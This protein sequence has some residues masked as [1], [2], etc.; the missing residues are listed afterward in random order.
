MGVAA[1]SCMK[2]QS[3]SALSAIPDQ[4]GRAPSVFAALRHRNY[5]LYFGG[6]LVSNAGTWMQAIA[7]G[8]LVYQL[9]HSDLMLGIVG[10]AAA[11]PSLLVTPWGGV[12]VDRMP[13]R[14]LLLMTQIGAM[15]LAF[16]LAALTFSGLVREWQIVL[17]AA[18]LGFVNAFDA[19]ARQA[20]VVEMVGRE[21]LPNAIALN[22]LMFNSARVI[23][24]A[25][26]GILLTIVGA[27]WCFTINGLSFLA[28]L[29]GLAA[30]RM[31]DRS[32]TGT[33][34]SP[35]N[36]L[37]QGLRYLRGEPV[38]TGILF[39]SLF[40]SVFGFSYSTLLPAF[41]ERVLHQGAAVYGWVTSATGVGAVT[42]ALLIASQRSRRP[43]GRWLAVSG[44]TFPF[45]LALF[46]FTSQVPLS[47]MLAFGLGFGFM[48]QFTMMNTL[49]QTRVD[50][51]L[52]GRVMSLYALTFSG[53]A[54]FGN[55][56]IGALSN[57]VGL[58][59]AMSAFAAASLLL[60][61][62]VHQ[63]VPQIRKLH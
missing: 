18:G 39:L 3:S 7:Q 26:G 13:K 28:V 1:E 2:S 46:S 8:W 21:D 62:L 19:P 45:V 22:A 52:R 5:Q 30:M 24:P 6:Q 63:R 20:F 32:G 12:V 49:L 48:S 33:G 23:G 60:A 57:K 54:P 15:L 37:W 34:G 25:I 41:V 11:I 42:G 44:I 36:Q 55:L 14:R 27:G 9:S 10:F 17:L 35:F 16:I 31:E 4:Q 61:L 43:R 38:L 53:L 59:Y 40:F 58:S 47:L 50:D 29:V 56:A 51:R